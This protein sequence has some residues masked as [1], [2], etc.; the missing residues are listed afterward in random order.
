MTSQVH[1]QQLDV[2]GLPMEGTL[3]T[4]N[5]SDRQTHNAGVINKVSKSLLLMP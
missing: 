2:H 4:K 3:R 1:L 5:A